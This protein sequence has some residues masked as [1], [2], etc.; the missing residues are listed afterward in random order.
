M[1]LAWTLL[2]KLLPT[3]RPHPSRLSLVGSSSTPIAHPH[4]LHTHTCIA[5]PQTHCTRAPLCTPPRIAH[6]HPFSLALPSAPSDQGPMHPPLASRSPPAVSPAFGAHVNISSGSSESGPGSGLWSLRGDPEPHPSPQHRPS[7]R[8]PIG[9][10]RPGQELVGSSG[11]GQGGD[12][13]AAHNGD[14]LEP[15]N[16]TCHHHHP[17]C[18]ANR[19]PSDQLGGLQFE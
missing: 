11:P 12:M 14:S 18:G 1:L 9:V 16:P 3:H 6:P 5:H 19:W 10:L 8:H 7:C 17:C 2:V 13:E 4:P 15:Q